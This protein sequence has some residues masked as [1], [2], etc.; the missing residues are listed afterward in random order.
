M[1]IVCLE[2]VIACLNGHISVLN[3]KRHIGIPLQ[4]MPDVTMQ[5]CLRV[6]RLTIECDHF[7][8][9]W[10]S[11]GDSQGTCAILAPYDAGHSEMLVDDNMATYYRELFFCPLPKQEHTILSKMCHYFTVKYINYIFKCG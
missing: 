1:I 2:I 4:M 8:M 7:N 11:S 9:I 10:L 6:C 5:A 3:N